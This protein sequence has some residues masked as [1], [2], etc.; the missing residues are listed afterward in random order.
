M[1]VGALYYHQERYWEA[2]P[3]FEES[4]ATGPPSAI[5]QR[6][7][8]DVYRH[9]GRAAEAAVAYRS[10]RDIAQAELARNPREAYSRILLALVCAFLGDRDRARAEAAQAL[11]MEPQNAEVRREAVILYEALGQR[12]DS[13]RLLRDG[14]RDP[15][16]ELSRQPDVK[17]LQADP[18]FQ[19]LLRTQ[20]TR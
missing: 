3:Y 10:A 19:E 13:L 5:R 12:E 2:A 16:E 14:P 1:N 11:A 18:R 9:L 20:T 4:V 7:L 15:L 17:D 8:G 6:D